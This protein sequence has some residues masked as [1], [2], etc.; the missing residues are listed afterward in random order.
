[1]RYP[2]GHRDEA[3]RRIVLEAGRLFR[4][5]GYDGVGVDEIMRAAGLTHGGFYGH[6]RSKAALFRAV[7]ADAHDFNLRMAARAATDDEGLRREAMALVGYYLDPANRDRVGQGCM[8]ASLSGDAARADADARGAWA[9]QVRDL[10]TQF[11]RGLP[12]PAAGLAPDANRPDPRGM[13]A[14]ALCVGGL[15]LARG[16]ADETLAAAMLAA[17]RAEVARVLA[18]ADPGAPSDATSSRRSRRSS[19]AR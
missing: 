16:M 2:P 12:P 6:F 1:M 8:L 13:A 3:R 5:K 11:A 7:L 9:G 17:C 10:A 14:V 19:P 15:T 4:S 18:V